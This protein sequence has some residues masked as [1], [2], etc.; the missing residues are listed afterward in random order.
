MLND[1]FRFYNAPFAYYLVYVWIK[2]ELRILSRI[3]NHRGLQSAPRKVDHRLWTD[4]LI[5]WCLL[6][7]YDGNTLLCK[8]ILGRCPVYSTFWGRCALRQ[9]RCG[10][11]LV[12]P[13][14]IGL[15]KVKT[16]I[17]LYKI[18]SDRSFQILSWT[19]CTSALRSSQQSP[20][21][22]FAAISLHPPSDKINTVSKVKEMMWVQDHTSLAI[23]CDACTTASKSAEKLPSVVSDVLCVWCCSITFDSP[24][25]PA[26]ARTDAYMVRI[27]CAFALAP[28]RSATKIASTRYPHATWRRRSNNDAK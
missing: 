5:K 10:I 8:F 22:S 26:V 28:H 20:W 21:S 16:T 6:F 12:V 25:W 24:K 27:R 18:R 2:T 23:A 14:Y 4:P 11:F 17:I 19:W 1:K 3:G 13:R 15:V 7:V 9:T